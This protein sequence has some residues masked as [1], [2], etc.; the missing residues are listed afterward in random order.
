MHEL[1]GSLQ[2]LLRSG[3]TGIG[4]AAC[5]CFLLLGATAQAQLRPLTDAVQVGAGA[6]HGCALTMDGGVKCWGRNESGQ[7]GDGTTTN[8]LTPVD[9][10]G[11]ASGVAAISA[12]GL[13]TCA[14]TTPAP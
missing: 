9:V 7:L 5:F 12:S 14:L 11:L 13:H 2:R 10:S 8:S 1:T 4:I 3:R 6:R